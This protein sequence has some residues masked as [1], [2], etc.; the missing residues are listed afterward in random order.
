MARLLLA[1]ALLCSLWSAP[2]GAAGWTATDDDQLL[3]ELRSGAIRL[4]DGVRGYQR[5]T[6]QCV[7]LSDL[8]L[9]LDL[10]IRVDRATGRASG[11]VFASEETIAVD[12]MAD[13]VTLAGRRRPLPPDAISE[14]PEG[15]CVGTAALGDWL[16]VALRPDLGN[17]SL[18]LETSRKLPFQLAAERRARAA[19]IRPARTFDLG[20][21]PQAA[22]PY[23]AWRTPAVDVVASAGATATPGA[24]R[25][26]DLRY[27]VFA[28]GEVAG[29]SV[30]A[31][32]SSDGRGVPDRLRARAY[33]AD[34]TGGL[35]GGATLIEAGDVGGVTSPLV[36]AGA[37][38]R[39][40]A[41]T[42]RPLL[43]P[44]TFT[45]T[46]FTGDLPVGWEAELYRNDQ[47]IAFATPR[48]DGRYD[49]RAVPLQFGENRLTVV[50]YGPQ[51][52]VRRETRTVRVG[53][54]AVPPGR[55]W[56]WLS[57]NETGQDLVGWSRVSRGTSDGPR[58]SLGVEHGLD[59]RTSLFAFAHSFRR[60]GHQ[61]SAA[62]IGARH[63]FGG[64]LAEFGVAIEPTGGHAAQLLVVGGGGRTSWTLGA[65][66]AHRFASDRIRDG[67]ARELSATIDSA[68]G[69][70]LTTLPLHAGLRFRQDRSGRSRLEAEGRASVSAGRFYLTGEVNWN[71]SRRPTAGVVGPGVDATGLSVDRAVSAPLSTLDLDGLSA[72]LLAS[73]SVGKVRLR[74]A[75]R[76][77]VSPH[78]RLDT[79][80]ASA[81]WAAGE[82][83]RFRLEAGWSGRGGGGSRR[84]RISAGYSRRFDRLALGGRLEA[85]SDGAV[86]A[87]IDLQFSLAPREGGGVRLSHARLASTGRAEVRVFRDANGDG[88]RQPDEPWE[89]DVQLIAGTAQV[90]ALTDAA[91]HATVEGLT[92]Y[93]AVLVGIDAGS[94]PD[95][96][97]SPAGP[98][99][100]VVPRPGVASVI[101]LPLS[102]AGAVEG[103]LTSERGANLG[104]VDLELVDRDD[105]VVATTR[106]DYDG[107]FAFERAPHGRLRLR[108]GALAAAALSVG[109]ETGV[110]VDITDADPVARVGTVVAKAMA[111]PAV[112]LDGDRPMPAV[113]SRSGVTA[114]TRAALETAEE[115][116]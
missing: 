112:A 80:D 23:R 46:S 19:A 96:F 40:V 102:R 111:G 88:V 45:T 8:V 68:L 52:Q 35:P 54:S 9:A 86:A 13:M 31:R 114:S 75:A 116:R 98:G 11:W 105:T 69:G 17:A 76:F 70:G 38:G 42:N 77:A 93:R 49:F 113:L 78:R 48:A 12:R 59:E 57:A 36:T 115:R 106:S 81:E 97:L 55:T 14:V 89:R 90:R 104:G 4:G 56:Y 22:T 103:T 92:P 18:F 26:G 73:G 28:A 20:R 87:G 108:I 34:P 53:D 16:G 1:L 15:W 63:G 3:F 79:L 2:A 62:E 74:A 72:A 65:L 58:A 64:A 99:K 7:V 110:A 61:R 30:D 50:L 91:G 33:R 27:E 47:L 85:S 94:L 43:Q 44:D 82:R 24:R 51:G 10:P 5:A 107:W 25:R 37:Q 95:P 60:D 21:L 84:G 39:G 109:V 29:L 66:T 41:V 83:G 71:R 6:D 32:L 100:V 67:T 101:D